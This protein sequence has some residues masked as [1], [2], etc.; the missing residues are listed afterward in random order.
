[1]SYRLGLFTSAR[2]GSNLP[3]LEMGGWLVHAAENDAI[4]LYQK[5]I[6]EAFKRGDTMTRRMFEEIAECAQFKCDCL[7]FVCGRE[8]SGFSPVSPCC[9]RS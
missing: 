7:H 8:Q 9:L 3:S 6:E 4:L 2:Y 1:M 5:I